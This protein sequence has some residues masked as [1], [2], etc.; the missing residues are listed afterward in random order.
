[1]VERKSPRMIFFTTY[2]YYKRWHRVL[3][4]YIHIHFLPSCPF[5]NN[6]HSVY[7]LSL[8]HDA[9]R[10]KAESQRVAQLRD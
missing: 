7:E 9:F 8:V 4:V 2:G 6:Q 10:E 5:M 3:K 1:M